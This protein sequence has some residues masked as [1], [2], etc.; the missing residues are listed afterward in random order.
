MKLDKKTFQ[1][2]INYL[3]DLKEVVKIIN[4]LHKRKDNSSLYSHR[5]VNDISYQFIYRLDSNQPWEL[6]KYYNNPDKAND[7]Y[8]A[9][10][11]EELWVKISQA[12]SECEE[13]SEGEV[14]E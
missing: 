3:N 1:Q 10:I 13:E 9:Q 4:K 6:I 14:D 8:I 2:H 5:F 7:E 12:E 11:P